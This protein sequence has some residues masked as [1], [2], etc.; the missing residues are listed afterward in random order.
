MMV[1][2]CVWL[3]VATVLTFALRSVGPLWRVAAGSLIWPLV[4]F[5]ALASKAHHSWQRAT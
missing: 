4:P 2:A 5:I 3:G 1:A